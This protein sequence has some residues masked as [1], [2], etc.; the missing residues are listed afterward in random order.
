MSISSRLLTFVAACAFASLTLAAT[1]P[2]PATGKA[3]PAPKTVKASTAKTL[4]APQ[5]RMVTCS[6]E[7]TGKKGPER[8]AF[9]SSCMKTHGSVAATAR[10]ASKHNAKDK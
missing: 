2:T 7:A 10:Q 3:A 5:Q 4:T 9:M 1:P 8:R 6:K